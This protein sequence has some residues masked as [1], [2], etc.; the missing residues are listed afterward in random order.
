MIVELEGDRAWRQ[1]QRDVLVASDC[2]ETKKLLDGELAHPSGP[3]F[4][5]TGPMSVCDEVIFQDFQKTMTPFAAPSQTNIATEF[6][7]KMVF[8]LT[9]SVCGGGRWDEDGPAGSRQKSEQDDG[10]RAD[11]GAAG[12][13]TRV[14]G[15]NNMIRRVRRR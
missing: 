10:G 4:R 9:P 14:R 12:Q 1:S 3:L 2:V 7:N 5:T 8:A 15:A 6:K 13:Q 11:R